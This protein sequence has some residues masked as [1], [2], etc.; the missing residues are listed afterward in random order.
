[1]KIFDLHCD[2]IYEC[3]TKKKSLQKNEFQVDMEKLKSGGS[4]AQCF[5]IFLD[6]EDCKKRGVTPFSRYRQMYAFFQE[7]LKREE[8]QIRLV[9]EMDTLASNYRQGKL[10]AILT[11]E[12]ADVLEG[13]SERLNTLYQDGVR[14]MT[15]T[16]NY[17]NELGFPHTAQ[18]GLKKFGF[19]VVERMN[20]AGML[21]DVSHLSDAGF[22]DVLK[23]GKKPIVASHSCARAL[24]ANSRNLSDE[25]L[26][27]LGNAGGVVG[28]NFF[29]L[30]L[31][32]QNDESRIEQVVAHVRHMVSCAGVE[33]VAFGSDF[34]G[35]D[36]RVEWKNF[37]GMQLVVEALGRYF[38]QEELEK[39][40]YKNAERVFLEQ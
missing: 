11:V 15:L 40:C 10:S 4:Y 37:A 13:K 18:K 34:D 25:M 35:I 16:W 17:E 23:T 27:A 22:W 26:K 29:R 33:S 38:S 28:V 9:T 14:L 36:E 30:F 1:M 7:E 2:T 19:E 3:E 5:A 8:A 24:C 31:A 12:G 32:E 6:R 39:I 20:E 21:I